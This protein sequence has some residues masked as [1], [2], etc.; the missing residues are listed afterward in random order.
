MT[1]TWFQLFRKKVEP[2]I[3]DPDIFYLFHSYLTVL[4][5]LFNLKQFLLLDITYIILQLAVNFVMANL[6]K[7]MV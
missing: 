3:N 2:F 5:F 6:S 7:N 1:K 4:L